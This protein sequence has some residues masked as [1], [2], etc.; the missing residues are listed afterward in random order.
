MGRLATLMLAVAVLA[1]SAAVARPQGSAQ[2]RYMASQVDFFAMRIERAQELGDPM[3]EARLK[4]HRAAL[5]KQ[6]KDRCPG[7]GNGQA[8]LAAL[9]E[10]MKLAAQG[11][12]TFFTFGAM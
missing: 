12:L 11:A 1:P 3:W 4:G 2:C 7:Y 6:L 10:L 9:R 8:A 5:E